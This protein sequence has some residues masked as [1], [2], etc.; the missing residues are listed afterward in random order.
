MSGLTLRLLLLFSASIAVAA[1]LPVP[2]N[3]RI[4][5]AEQSLELT[6]DS[7]PNVDG[8]HIYDSLVL[9]G[10]KNRPVR[11]NSTLITSGPRFTYIWVIEGGK[12]LRIIKGYEHHISVTAV[13]TEK[14]VPKESARSKSAD[15]RYFEKFGRMESRERLGSVLAAVQTTPFLPVE[16]KINTRAAFIAFMTGPGRVLMKKLKETVD[17]LKS[18]A[19][20]PVST[21]LVNLLQESGL[22]AYRIEGAFIQEYH[23]FVALNVDNVEYI[24]DFTADQFVPNASPVVLPRDFAFL[25]SVGRLAKSGMPVYRAEKIYSP[26]QSKLTDGK[27][28]AEFRT[29][30]EAVLQEIRKK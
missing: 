27:E 16:Q 2:A 30:Y 8:Y 1:K 21:V 14:G 9:P 12:R 11:V 17:P 19:C 24:L 23:T 7:L 25:N 28:A 22:Y 15:N 6:W 3:L 4:L 10:V 26:E 20:A 18:G 29:L 5:Y 13:F